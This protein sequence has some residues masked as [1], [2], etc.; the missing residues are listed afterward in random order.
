MTTAQNDF[1]IDINLEYV[2]QAEIERNRAFVSR[3]DEMY[4]RYILLLKRSYAMMLNDYLNTFYADDVNICTEEEIQL[5]L[6]RFNELCGTFYTVDFEIT[7]VV[8][9]GPDNVW[10]DTLIWDDSEIWED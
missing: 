4:Y 10:D 6:D 8:T 2:K 7:D 1:L 3:E 9:P 5:V